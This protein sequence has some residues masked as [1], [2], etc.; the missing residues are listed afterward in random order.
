MMK[1][2]TAEAAA[3]ACG[4]R[5]LGHAPAGELTAVTTDSRHVQPG[6]LFAALRGAR[7]DGHDFVPGVL[8]SGAACALVERVPAGAEGCMILV[9]D[10]LKALQSIA[11]SYRSGF[12]IPLIGV[13]GSAGKTTTKEMLAA[14]LG[15][16][17]CVHKTAGNFNN[18]LGVPLTLFSLREE[19]TA[20]VV[21]LGVSHPGDMA[22]IASVAR[23]TAAVYTNIGD[24]HLEFLGSREGILAEKSVMNAYLPPDGTVIV[25]GDD[26]LLAALPWAGPRLTYGLGA[27]N[28]VRG[29]NVEVQ[30][31]GSLRFRLVC[32]G[33]TVPVVIPAFGD[34][35]VYAALA[36]AAAGFS[37][38]LTGEQIARG[39]PDF[40]QAAHRGELLR[41]GQ[42]TVIDDSYNANPTSMASAIRSLSHFPGR[43]VCVLGDM[44]E[45]GQDSAKL[46][47]SVGELA[48]ESGID[49]VLTLGDEAEHIARGAGE[50]IAR[51][52]PDRESLFSALGELIRPGDTVLVKASR[53]MRFE[54]AARALAERF[55]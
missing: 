41:T 1:H 50:N 13:T 55:L 46:H 14:V 54:E 36:A 43:R 34:H 32:G 6:S 11:A 35:M 15:Q 39:V 29:E 33:E 9:E 25:N 38:G 52:L 44:L 23:P 5:I 53:G 49:L 22:R 45:L 51:H 30:P 10:V 24:A 18:D 27:A 48:R 47:F 31:D 19:H 26:P 17:Y 2:L 3:R 40:R 4:G 16:R 7:A 8:A 37:L 28:D 12:D 21:E 42:I 20:A